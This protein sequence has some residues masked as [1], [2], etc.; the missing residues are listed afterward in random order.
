MPACIYQAESTTR[1]EVMTYGQIPIRQKIRLRE[2]ML[3]SSATR[4]QDGAGQTAPS[5]TA[6]ELLANP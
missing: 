4:P 2:R 5:E 1:R 6:A 3:D